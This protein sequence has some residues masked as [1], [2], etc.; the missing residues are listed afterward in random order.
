[1]QPFQCHITIEINSDH[2]N[3]LYQNGER[4]LSGNLQNRSYANALGD[5]LVEVSALAMYEAAKHF[6]VCLTFRAFCNNAD[7]NSSDTFGTTL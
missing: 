7:A 3:Y 5:S 2:M 1:M 6:T 4:A